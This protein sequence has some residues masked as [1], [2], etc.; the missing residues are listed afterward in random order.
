MKIKIDFVTNSSSVNFIILSPK[1]ISEHLLTDI[2]GSV[3]EK[4]K[5]FTS[6][7]ELIAYTQKD[8][9]DWVSRIRGPHRFYGLSEQDYTACKDIIA[10][11]RIAIRM[12][13]NRNYFEEIDNI[14]MKLEKLGASILIRKST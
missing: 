13:C 8:K 9:C 5:C 14:V 2:S 4:Y 12:E 1:L 11:G 7:E 6:I 3:I 10:K